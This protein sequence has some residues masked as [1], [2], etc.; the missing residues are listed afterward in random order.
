VIREPLVTYEP[1]RPDALLA[2]LSL[3]DALN[4]E[5]RPTSASGTVDGVAVTLEIGRAALAEGA[6]R[7]LRVRAAAPR[8]RDLER[9]LYA[10][11]PPPYGRTAVEAYEGVWTS[12]EG[13]LRRLR[14]FATEELCARL[15]ELAPLRAQLSD[16][17]VTGELSPDE[18]TSRLADS[19]RALVAIERAA[20]AA[21]AGERVPFEDDVAEAVPALRQATA[22]LGL[23]LT[24]CPLGFVGELEGHRVTASRFT[25][26][27]NRCVL[28]VHVA[29]HQALP[30]EWDL[31][32][33]RRKPW[34]RIV[35][36]AKVLLRRKRWR[37]PRTGDFSFD[38]RF[39]LAHGELSPAAR[40]LGSLR[41]HL[42]ELADELWFRLYHD[43][44]VLALNVPPGLGA[45]EVVHLVRRGVEISRM[46]GGEPEQR[47]TA[48]PFR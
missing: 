17:G 22:A 14:A 24:S 47:S 4:L 29:F 48:G 40:A 32:S 23:T 10:A 7:T 27:R 15:R 30:G 34:R 20:A 11:P 19:A 12:G 43:E 8:P 42:I 3:A 31:W 35:A 41:P 1:A 44:L 33:I 9:R 26:V 5:R 21:A 25:L 2:L 28:F 37:S 6:G 36:A 39:Y 16:H 45:D 18:P 46:V 38:R 13:S